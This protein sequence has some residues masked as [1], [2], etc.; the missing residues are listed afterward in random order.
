VA[1]LLILAV[2]TAW[3]LYTAARLNTSWSVRLLPLAYQLV[4]VALGIWGRSRLAR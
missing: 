3:W 2:F 1:T 4:F